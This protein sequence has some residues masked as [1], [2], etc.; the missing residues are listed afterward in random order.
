VADQ[1]KDR[2][3][4]FKRKLS[5][6]ELLAVVKVVAMYAEPDDPAS[7]SQRSYDKAREGAG[8]SGTPR[9][10]RI[11]ERLNLPWPRVVALAVSGENKELVLGS[12]R[13]KQQ[14]EHLTKAEVVH[15]MQMVAKHLGVEEMNR[16]DYDR[17]RAEIIAS[18]KR[19]HVVGSGAATLI[20]TGQMIERRA[21]SWVKAL[22]WSGLKRRTER[23]R[24]MYPAERALDDFIGDFG[25]QPS[26]GELSTYQKLRGIATRGMPR[27]SDFVSWRAEQLTTGLSS[28]HGDVPLG[29][30]M[31]L[32][33]FDPSKISPPPPGFAPH[34][35]KAP[36]IE[37][38][39]ADLNT[40]LDLHEGSTMSQRD[41]AHLAAEH[42]LSAVA[43]IQRAGKKAGG[44]T[45]GQLRDEVVAERAD[46][47]RR[48][49]RD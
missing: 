37:R 34:G 41:Y 2:H 45:W 16:G 18:E 3:G 24:K 10:W 28:R 46:S 42:G 25:Y 38:A 27:G 13:V 26:V 22:D 6:Q 32:D 36:S 31:G 47:Q 21:G 4:L 20:P 7:I 43:V 29:R 35:F 17:G 1:E 8:V 12:A 39:K 9:A 33:R 49:G 40:A 44:Q 23:L 15:Y 30:E 19:A 14:R 11:A 48:A 5:D